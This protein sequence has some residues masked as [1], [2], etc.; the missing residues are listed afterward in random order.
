M[1][2]SQRIMVEIDDNF[3]TQTFDVC[4]IWL[5]KEGEPNSTFSMAIM[6]R[7]VSDKDYDHLPGAVASVSEAIREAVQNMIRK[8]QE[9]AKSEVANG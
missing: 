6:L 4:R 2:E 3:R 8:S 1:G 9:Q 5:A 7:C